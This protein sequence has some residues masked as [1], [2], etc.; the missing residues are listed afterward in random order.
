MESKDL[1]P[2]FLYP[3]KL[4]FRMGGQRLPRQ[5]KAEGVYHHLTYITRN[6]KG[7]FLRRRRKRKDKKY[8]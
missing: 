6:V 8:E 3:A 5:E 7:S 2:R 4:S 1:Q